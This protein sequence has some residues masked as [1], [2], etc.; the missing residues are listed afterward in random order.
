M[1]GLSWSILGHTGSLKS[2][3]EAQRKPPFTAA[4][5][6]A[7]RM[8]VDVVTSKQQ[9]KIKDGLPNSLG[10]SMVGE[11]ASRCSQQMQPK[12]VSS[13]VLTVGKRAEPSYPHTLIKGCRTIQGSRGPGPVVSWCLGC[14][15]PR[16]SYHWPTAR[17]T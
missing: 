2:S 6:F 4:C 9:V 10:P 8:K 17:R 12:S 14:M 5:S 13:M 15:E 16:P 3:N 11:L 1:D 7:E